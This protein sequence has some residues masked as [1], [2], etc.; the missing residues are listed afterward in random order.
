MIGVDSPNGT[1][2]QDEDPFAAQPPERPPHTHRF[3]S[4]DTQLF[5]ANRASSSPGQARRVLQARL[6]ETERRLQETSKLGTTLVEQRKNISERLKDVEKQQTGE[7]IDPELKKRLNDIEKEYSEVSRES[8]RA[9][10]GS[11][12][13]AAPSEDSNHSAA[14]DGRRSPTKFS[15]DATDS[16]SKLNVPRKQ[17]NQAASRAQDLDFAAE[18]TTSLIDQV[19]QLQ[20]A[21]AERDE[22]LKT[23][24]SEKS[25]L[26]QETTGL[27]MRLKSLDENEQRYKDEN[28]NLET[29]THEMMATI[30]ESAAREQKLRQALTLAASEK[31]TTQHELEEV[32]QSHGK[33]TEDFDAL[34]KSHDTELGNLQRSLKTADEEREAMLRKHEDLISQNQELAKGLAGRFRDA[35]NPLDG[36]APLAD[37]E[38][39]PDRSDTEYSP[40]PSPS[41]LGGRHSALETETLRSSLHHAHRM[42][43]SLKKDMNR[44]KIE[45]RDLKRALQDAK[46]EVDMRRGGHDSKK[47]KMKNQQEATKRQARSGML[48]SS[49]NGKTDILV[50]DEDWQELNSP[51]PSVERSRKFTVIPGAF[52][53]DQP[54]ETEDGFETANEANTTT[55]AFET[56]AESM[57][58]ETSDDGNETETGLTRGNTVRAGVSRPSMT[59]QRASFH[60]TASTSDDDDDYQ[61]RKTP[62]Q[63]LPQK[64][65][66]R[67]GRNARRSRFGSEQP[68]SSAPSSAQ[69]SPASFVDNSEQGGQSLFN[70]L[71]GVDDADGDIDATPSKRGTSSHRSTPQPESMHR[72]SLSNLRRSVTPLARPLTVVRGNNLSPEPPVPRLP[73]VDSGMMTEAWEPTP[74]V[75]TVEVPVPMQTSEPSAP[76]EP[77]KNVEQTSTPIQQGATQSTPHQ[78]DSGDNKESERN[79]SPVGT[80]EIRSNAPNRQQSSA[81]SRRTI[82]DR[83]LQM[84][85]NIIPTFDPADQSSTAAPNE[86]E[87]MARASADESR[88][89]IATPSPTKGNQEVEMLGETPTTAGKS[90]S[91]ASRSIK[92]E[93]R[94]SPVSRKTPAP[95]LGNSWAHPDGASGILSSVFDTQTSA[96]PTTA[97][98]TVDTGR[99]RGPPITAAPSPGINTVVLKAELV[100]ESCQTM[101][102]SEQIERLMKQ[103]TNPFS[104]KAPMPSAAA[105]RPLAEIG[106]PSPSPPLAGPSQEF[107][108]QDRGRATE[109]RDPNAPFIKSPKRPVSVGNTRQRFS[110]QIPPLPAD[111]QQTIAAAAQKAPELAPGTMGPPLAPASSYRGNVGGVRPPSRSRTPNQRP[112]ASMPASPASKIGTIPRARYSMTNRSRI[113]HRSSVSSFE[114]ELDARFNIRPEDGMTMPGFESG[115]DP[116]MI[117]AITQTMIGEFLWKYTR[118]AGR[119]EMSSNRHKRWFWVHPYTRTL[120]WSDQD[121][122]T[123]GRAQLKAKS[124]AI[125]AVRVV[126]DDNPMPPGLHRKSLVIMTPGRSVKFTATTSQ[127]HE[128]WFNALSYLLLRTGAD[129]QANDGYLTAEDIAEFNPSPNKRWTSGGAS[130]RSWRSNKSNAP[131]APSSG[132]AGV[133]TSSRYSTQQPALP[134]SSTATGKHPAATAGRVSNSQSFS[135]AKSR[136]HM[137]IGSRISEYWK[138]ASSSRSRRGS[139]GSRNSVGATSA[140]S[141]EDVRK[142]Y[143]TR[144]RDGGLENVRA[145]CDGRFNGGPLNYQP[146]LL[147]DYAD[148]MI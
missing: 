129:G 119:G 11:R 106:A 112:V 81:S 18:I 117:Q 42:I 73:M 50:D 53:S 36:E 134:P 96:Q 111:H 26:E 31:N 101:L 74:I 37:D 93:S 44:E 145:C 56:G 86:N 12:A 9:F 65:R 131:P 142:V 148:T 41:K 100:D 94:G 8:I 23:A 57:A 113:S 137:S 138:P 38:A 122:H 90:D 16:P 143:D 59:A 43:Q 108:S 67:I 79:I 127:R 91:S 89:E 10:S 51:I 71:N 63:S 92:E 45:N 121:P 139:V 5:N 115:T 124:V 64:Y 110:N 130:L 123:A 147:Q 99:E 24:N 84:F 120:Y 144:D 80:P 128:T 7:E 85:S 83:P 125:E 46:D 69:G 76:A 35:Q 103:R 54:T 6:S 2:R 109:S 60:S 72:R 70:E 132:A 136:G 15:R 141:A 48:G 4:F 27:S 3:S 118:K 68:G 20:A 133:S 135:S 19:K 32:Q 29:Q 58:G 75:K 52:D 62:V 95:T 1:R 66:L 107:P 98:T 17:R 49:R 55:D 78:S 102:S 40:P 33:L 114:S 25:R 34:R 77:A 87:D 88:S 146:S 105:M 126:V 22:S 13:D 39:P 14:L 116:R 28:W 104:E 140:T 97:K 82:W 30:K 61:S 21:L 47:Q